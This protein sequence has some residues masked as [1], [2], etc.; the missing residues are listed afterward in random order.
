MAEYP[1]RNYIAGSD[2]EDRDEALIDIDFVGD[3][4]IRR[5][6]DAP[7]TTITLK[8]AGLTPAE[9]ETVR[10]FLAANRLV[11]FDLYWRPD[12]AVISV[13]LASERIRWT[14]EGDK[15]ACE[16]QVFRVA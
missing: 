5:L 9:R 2:F 7:R 1:L 12:A 16:F 14:E 4:H 13:L 8:H 15:W 10:S 6:Q 11:P 3:P